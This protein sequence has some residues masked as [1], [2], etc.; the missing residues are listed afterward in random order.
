MRLISFGFSLAFLAVFVWFGA[1]VDLGERTFIGHLRAIASS[2][3]SQ[4]L[5]DGIKDRIRDF[6]G[7]DAAQEAAK[8]ASAA[9][10]AAKDVTKSYLERGGTRT[11][12]GPGAPQEKITA[13]D[14]K[15]MNEQMKRLAG[16]GKSGKP[17]PLAAEGKTN[18]PAPPREGRAVPRE[19]D[20]KRDN[21]PKPN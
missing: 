20:K 12:F 18:Q 9:R 7:I 5:W 1:T 17:G 10:D 19:S 13:G 11:L 8:R 15:Q 14:Q 2:K 16:E 21:Q 3:E 4:A 6:V